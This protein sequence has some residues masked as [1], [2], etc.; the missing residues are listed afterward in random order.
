[1]QKASRT[2][3][4]AANCLVTGCLSYSIA[5]NYRLVESNVYKY[6]KIVIDESR[7]ILLISYT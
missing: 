6:A 5:S 4:I 7:Q 3:I 2:S 1:M